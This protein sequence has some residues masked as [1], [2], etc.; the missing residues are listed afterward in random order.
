MNNDVELFMDKKYRDLL[1]YNLD[2]HWTAV[3]S[4]SPGCIADGEIAQEAL[5]TLNVARRLWLESRREPEYP[6][7]QYPGE[8]EHTEGASADAAMSIYPFSGKYR[9]TMAR[10][11]NQESFTSGTVES[12]RPDRSNARGFP[13]TQDR[14]SLLPTEKE[15]SSAAVSGHNPLP[16]LGAG[17]DVSVAGKYRQALARLQIPD[18][19]G[20]VARAGDYALTIA[21]QR[22]SLDVAR[23]AFQYS[24]CRTAR[25]FERRPL[26]PQTRTRGGCVEALP[27]HLCKSVDT[28]CR[29]RSQ[30]QH[31]SIRNAVDADI[32]QVSQAAG[33]DND[34]AEF[35]NQL[36][37]FGL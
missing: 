18:P 14:P 7:Q 25:C 36:N 22:H 28:N 11:K 9:T 17:K 8:S 31:T 35:G 20:M 16:G 34:L 19:Q 13:L 21:R 12:E 15:D 23:M 2:G 32:S 30:H 6:H 10:F 24:Y 29:N 26:G 1:C 27:V 5:A 3:H 33:C 37:M 4:E